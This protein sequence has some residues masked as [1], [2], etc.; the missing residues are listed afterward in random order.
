M[1]CK[2]KKL[3]WVTSIDNV[4]YAFTPIGVYIIDRYVPRYEQF[5]WH[6]AIRLH[7]EGEQKI[8]F[9]NIEIYGTIE[10]AQKDAQD[11]FNRI[12]REMS[13]CDE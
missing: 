5:I 6:L 12:W 1:S 3:N 13:E 4:L 2:P 8:L 7:N 10:D 9:T 11:H